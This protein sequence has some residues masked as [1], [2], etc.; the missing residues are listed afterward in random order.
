MCECWEVCFVHFFFNS[1]LFP[2]PVQ[3]ARKYLWLAHHI[4]VK[5]KETRNNFYEVYVLFWTSCYLKIKLVSLRSCA[6]W[7]KF[8]F[9][10]NA[11]S[12]PV[13]GK[14]H[15]HSYRGAVAFLWLTCRARPLLSFFFFFSLGLRR[16]LESAASLQQYFNFF[17]FS[18]L[19]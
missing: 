15:V 19:T 4:P 6:L 17:K 11:T 2:C 5:L 1:L 10:L 3:G 16:K 8:C 9:H 18:S 12:T 13:R 7:V 14:L